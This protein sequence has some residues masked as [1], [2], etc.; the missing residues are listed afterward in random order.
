MKLYNRCLGNQNDKSNKFITVCFCLSVNLHLKLLVHSVAKTVL[1]CV[2]VLLR[3][4]KI[5]SLKKDL[6]WVEF[7]RRS[8]GGL[9]HPKVKGNMQK[10]KTISN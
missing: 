2:A 10:Q 3:Q 6:V 7:I 8:F 1:I 5:L 4:G 9:G